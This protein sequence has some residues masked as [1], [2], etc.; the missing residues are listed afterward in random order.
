MNCCGHIYLTFVSSASPA[1]PKQTNRITA[2]LRQHTS[3]VAGILPQ[4]PL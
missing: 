2:D 1:V 3:L 4:G